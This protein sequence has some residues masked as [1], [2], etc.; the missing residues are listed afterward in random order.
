MYLPTQNTIETT[1][2]L[3]RRMSSRAAA[4]VLLLLAFQLSACDS[5]DNSEPSQDIVDVAV[6]NDFDTLVAAIE[7][8]RLVSTLRGD[9][10]F[11]VFAPSDAAFADLPD[12]ALETLLQPENQAQLQAVLTYHVVPGRVTAEQVTSLDAAETVNG[13]TLSIE[14]QNGAVLVN[15]ATV[16]ATDIEASNGIIHVVDEVLLPPSGN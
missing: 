13:A 2:R 1:M 6:A 10:P 8:A 11:T 12:G 5:T 14:T 9:G 15:G 4:A 3:L 16:T 7:A